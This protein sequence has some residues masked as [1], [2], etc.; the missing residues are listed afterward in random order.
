[1]KRRLIIGGL[2]AASL[3]LG[4]GPALAMRDRP[5]TT[6]LGWEW[7]GGTKTAAGDSVDGP[8]SSNAYD[9]TEGGVV[10]RRGY[11]DVPLAEYSA[12]FAYKAGAEIDDG[13][14]SPRISVILADA[15]GETGEVIYLD[16]YHCPSAP[17]A[18]GWATTDFFRSGSSCTIHTSYG[19]FTGDD[20]L[21]TSA[22]G[23]AI[24]AAEGTMASYGFLIA[25]QPDA[26]TVDRV[27]FGGDVLSL[28]PADEQ[29]QPRS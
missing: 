20:L 17:N 5:G 12:A 7:Y 9:L 6:G 27:R 29:L 26:T 3:V 16:P 23:A 28:F 22:W 4:A 24:A 25:D 15:D 18:K 19:V 1:M 13:D 8:K 10:Y 21:G 14:G 11:W 2:V